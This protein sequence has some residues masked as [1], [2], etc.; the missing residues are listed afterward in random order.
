MK[1]TRN[2][3]SKS[4]ILRPPLI[5]IFICK[6]KENKCNA[7]DFCKISRKMIPTYLGANAIVSID[8][9]ASIPQFFV[10]TI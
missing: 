4:E 8:K 5:Y 7:L 3:K 1:D 2:K 6:K 9:N 10:Y